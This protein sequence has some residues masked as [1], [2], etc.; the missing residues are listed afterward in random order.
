MHLDAFNQIGIAIG[1]LIAIAII[2]PGGCL[3]IHHYPHPHNDC[4][5]KVGVLRYRR[6][7]SEIKKFQR[8]SNMRLL[9]VTIIIIIIR[10]Q[11]LFHERAL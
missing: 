7:Q 2:K 4:N 6:S 1:I 3:Q 11:I 8:V 5:Q 10:A 9:S